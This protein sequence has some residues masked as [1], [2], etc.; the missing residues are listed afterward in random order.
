[1]SEGDLVTPDEIRALLSEPENER[2]EF[3]AGLPPKDEL[4]RLIAAFANTEGGTLIIGVDD[5]SGEVVGLNH[6]GAV[7]GHVQEWAD[8]LSPRPEVHSGFVTLEPGKHVAFARVEKGAQ[9]PYLATGQAVERRGDQVAPINPE[10]IASRI[11]PPSADAVA[12]LAEAVASQS[13]QVAQQS[14]QIGELLRR[15]HWTR[16]LPVRV[17]AAAIG[18]VIGYAIGV[19]DPL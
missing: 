14:A 10:R 15:L 12:R 18:A 19:W 16:Q 7:A 9:V 1:M 2:L 13:E 6:P 5:S 17:G 11:L 3:E 8:Q 4:Q